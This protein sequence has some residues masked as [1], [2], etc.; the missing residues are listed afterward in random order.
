MINVEHRFA[1]CP[2]C[3]DE[4]GTS[5]YCSLCL[6]YNPQLKKEVREKNEKKPKAGP[7]SDKWENL[8]KKLAA[9]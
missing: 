6:Q 9:K 7:G 2:E 5:P 3:G 1:P 4:R 8:K